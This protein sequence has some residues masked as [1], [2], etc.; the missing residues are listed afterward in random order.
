LGKVKDG[1]DVLLIESLTVLVETILGY[2][3]DIEVV[4]AEE[5]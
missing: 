5:N 3:R 1:P 2:E 4:L